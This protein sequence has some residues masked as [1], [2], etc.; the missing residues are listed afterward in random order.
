MKFDKYFSGYADFSESAVEYV[1]AK[2]GCSGEMVFLN[3]ENLALLKLPKDKNS[4]ITIEREPLAVES[5]S[6]NLYY[7]FS[8]TRLPPHYFTPFYRKLYNGIKSMISGEPN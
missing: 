6:N 2:Y 3:C 7:Q 1:R 8:D 4:A 5:D